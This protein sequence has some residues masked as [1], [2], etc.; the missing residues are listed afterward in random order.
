[1]RQSTSKYLDSNGVQ[2]TPSPP[3]TLF[4]AVPLLAL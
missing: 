2:Q 1:V 4:V 3:R